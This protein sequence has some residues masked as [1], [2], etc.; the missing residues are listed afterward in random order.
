[1]YVAFGAPSHRWSEIMIE[2]SPYSFQTFD[3]PTD[4]NNLMGINDKGLIAGF[5]GSGETG[6]PNQGYLLTQSG[7]FIPMDFPNEAQTQLTGLNDRGISVGYF[8]PTNN[9]VPVDNQFGFYVKDGVF[10]AVNN[11]NTP[12]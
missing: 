5:Y 1:M 4:H 3:N 12:T 9:G 7:T 2:L 6:H 11:P 8:Y 10:I